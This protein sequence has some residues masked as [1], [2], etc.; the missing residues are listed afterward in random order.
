MQSSQPKKFNFSGPSLSDLS[1]INK[2][3]IEAVDASSNSA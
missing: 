3:P 2:K 1:E